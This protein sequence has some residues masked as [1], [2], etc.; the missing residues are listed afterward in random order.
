MKPGRQRR[1]CPRFILWF[2]SKVKFQ[3]SALL[4]CAEYRILQPFSINAM[5]YSHTDADTDTDAVTDADVDA[6]A[7]AKARLVVLAH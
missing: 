2:L 3:V 4:S 1:P 5:C 6:E 7:N